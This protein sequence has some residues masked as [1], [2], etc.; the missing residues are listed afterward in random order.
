MILE[1]LKLSGQ[2]NIVLKDKAGN[3]KEERVEKNLV[4]NAGL[5]YIASRMTGTSKAVMSHMALGSGTTAAAASQTDLVTLLGSREALDSATITGSNNEKVAYVSAFE[6]GDAT[7]AVTEAGIFNAASSGDMLC[8]TVFSVVNKAADDT[9]SV[10][11]T[12]TLAAS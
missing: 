5:A 6:A 11:W 2:L 3:I 8:R 12:I 10:T 4:V 1:N 9:M 7:G